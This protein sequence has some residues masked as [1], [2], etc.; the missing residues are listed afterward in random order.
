MTVVLGPRLAIALAVLTISA[1]LVVQLAGLGRWDGPAVAALR[2]TVQ[3][4]AASAVIVVVLRSMW[5]T[6]AFLL[7]MTL[8]GTATAARRITGSLQP[9]G[10]CTAIPIVVGVAPV[11]V[12]IIGSGALPLTPVAV[13]PTAGILL[14]NAM[15]ATSLA[16]KRLRDELTTR[17]GEY[18]AALSIG[19]QRPAAVA[20][21]GRPAAALALVPG[22]DQTRT[23]G[24]VTLPGAFIGVLLGGGSALQAGATQLLVLIGLLVVQSVAVAT[25]VALVARGLLPAG[26]APLPA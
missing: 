26:E 19:L 10:W 9:P 21:I 22:L 24:L 4:A 3:L 25:T 8:V 23:V 13:L 11:M 14:G 20:E 16:G 1:A 15:V 7:L 5:W 18:E 17:R 12:V 2:A 6:S